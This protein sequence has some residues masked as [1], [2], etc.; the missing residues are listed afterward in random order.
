MSE[1]GLEDGL[2][3]G[4]DAASLVEYNENGVVVRFHSRAAICSYYDTRQPN[5]AV[6]A[7]GMP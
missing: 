7:Q 2:R 3:L 5:R 4:Y 6:G 1:Y